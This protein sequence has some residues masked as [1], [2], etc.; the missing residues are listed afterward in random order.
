MKAVKIAKLAEQYN[1]SE[2]KI[3]AA[4]TKAGIAA[5]KGTVAGADAEAAL[6]ALD[7][8]FAKAAKPAAKAKAKAEPKP[9]AEAKKAPAKKD[10][11]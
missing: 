1:T 10:A 8:A 9:K 3:A 2:E 4:L 6:K 11:E 7:A 5:P